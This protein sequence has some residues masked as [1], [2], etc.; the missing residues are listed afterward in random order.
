MTRCSPKSIPI[1]HH[2]RYR[3][4]AQPRRREAGVTCRALCEVR[5]SVR[6]QVELLQREPGFPGHCFVQ[7]VARGNRLGHVVLRNAPEPHGQDHAHAPE[8]TTGRAQ[9]DTV[10][11]GVNAGVASGRVVGRG[12]HRRDVV[13]DGVPART[14]RGRGDRPGN[15]LLGDE[16]E[17]GDG[18]PGEA[19]Q[20]PQQ[21]LDPAATADGGPHGAVR[22]AAHA[23]AVQVPQ[24]NQGIGG[25]HPRVPRVARPDHPHG[26]RGVPVQ[27][28]QHL[29]FR[30]RG[31]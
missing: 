18:D 22:V 28:R 11:P 16:A 13:R 10:G 27:D 12:P 5:P 31:V 2:A 29:R 4:A 24:V 7:R 26:A 9:L 25:H 6:E 1:S 30:R 17:G 3:A 21:V 14:V 20:F 23:H 8:G 19:V 15:R